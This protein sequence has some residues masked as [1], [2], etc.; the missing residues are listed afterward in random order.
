MR[1]RGRQMTM[2]GVVVSDKM[3]K[4]AVVEVRKRALHRRYKKYI[5]QR[6]KYMAHNPIEGCGKGD[7]VEIRQSRPLS[8]N[9][10]WIITNVLRK[11]EILQ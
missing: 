2:V 9:K 6:R 3:Q 11:A 5:T 8:A 4:S 1:D 10:R 7:T